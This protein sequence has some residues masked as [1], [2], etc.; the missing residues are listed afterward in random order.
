MAPTLQIR[1]IGHEI[2]GLFVKMA[3]GDPEVSMF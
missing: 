2:V 3:E 1:A